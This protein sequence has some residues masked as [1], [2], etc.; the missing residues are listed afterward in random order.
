[1]DVLGLWWIG[2]CWIYIA[3]LVCFVF[4]IS[5]LFTTCVWICLQV[6]RCCFVLHWGWLFVILCIVGVDVDLGELLRWLVLMWCLVV[7]LIILF[8]IWLL[9]FGGCL[10][11]RCW[12]LLV[13]VGTD[14]YCCSLRLKFCVIYVVVY[15]FG[16]CC[17]FVV[18]V[19]CTLFNWC[20]GVLIFGWW[21]IVSYF[22]WVC[23][24]MI[25]CLLIVLIV[26]LCFFKFLLF[27]WV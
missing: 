11:F 3:W 16:V 27:V 1:M 25:V 18:M 20:L 12:V 22:C 9:L 24:S 7:Y 15:D 26:L 19:V 21:L 10:K 8:W 2:W 5:C 6:F 14:L 13:L 4:R 17:D 23:L